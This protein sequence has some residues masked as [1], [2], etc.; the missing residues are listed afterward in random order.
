MMHLPRGLEIQNLP[1]PCANINL[2]DVRIT[3]SK[4]YS[5]GAWEFWL[6]LGSSMVVIF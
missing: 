1:L 2:R 4:N 6:V 5:N 3:T